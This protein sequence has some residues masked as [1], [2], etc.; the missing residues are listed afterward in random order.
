MDFNDKIQD[1]REKAETKKDD[2]MDE[3]KDRLEE[4]RRKEDERKDESADM[5]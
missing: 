2:M 5:M 4:L 3:G 1:M